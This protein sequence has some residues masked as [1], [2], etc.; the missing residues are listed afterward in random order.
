MLILA[1]ANPT[2]DQA[3]TY[4]QQATAAEAQAE[5]DRTARDQVVRQLNTADPT[6]WT[7]K[8]LASALGLSAT[9]IRRA[10]G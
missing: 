2:I 6:R 5:Q 3:I 7:V 8:A 10:L 4:Q 1:H 9:T